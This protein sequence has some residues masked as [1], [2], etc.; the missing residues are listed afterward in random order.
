MADNENAVAVPVEPKKSGKGLF[1]IVAVVLVVVLGAGA[2]WFFLR[3]STAKGA[4]KETPQHAEKE[5][6]ATIKL[7][8][9]VVNLA[10]TESNAFLRLGL[11]LGLD[12]H[13]EKGEGEGE[14]GVPTA[15]LRDGVLSVLT[16]YRAAELLTP[17]GKKKLKEDLVK[18]LNEKAPKLGVADVFFTEFLVQ[19]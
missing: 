7:E 14:G 9:F 17:E 12:K 4:E 8:N 16:S 10:D 2:W 3:P 13:V 19:R 5:I 6:K 1:I 15:Q 11:E 18:S